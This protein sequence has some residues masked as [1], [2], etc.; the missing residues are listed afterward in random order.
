MSERIGIIAGSG[1]FPRLVAKG[2][3]EAGCSVAVCG[4]HGNADPGLE[5]EADGFLM[6]HLG[7]L[8]RMIDFFREQGVT[9]LCMAGAVSKPRALDFR[10]DVRAMRLL[11]S[12]RKNKGDDA[13]LRVI[14]GAFEHEGLQVLSAADLVPE[15]R[16]PAGVLGKTRPTEAIREAIAYGWPKLTLTGRLDIGQCMVVREAM[17]MAVECL[18]GT[19]ATLRRGAELGGAGCVALKMAKPGQEERVD[20]PSVGLQTIRILTEQ[21][22][23]ALVLE[24]GKT[25]F[26]DREE[27]VRLADK[28]GLCLIALSQEEAAGLAAEN[29]R[30]DSLTF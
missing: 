5:H 15:L 18:E 23:A 24:A 8:G 22:Y 2:A 28:N 7:Q 17:V 21:R 4:L 1:Q 3:H 6:V 14:I 29:G 20:L 27:A 13:L 30:Q 19:D 12:L 10:P 11:F 9:R 25:L 16:C 26:F